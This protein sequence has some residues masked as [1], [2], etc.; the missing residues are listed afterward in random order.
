M[1]NPTKPF[2]LK[3]VVGRAT[4]SISLRAVRLSNGVLAGPKGGDSAANAPE[5]TPA[6]RTQKIYASCTEVKVLDSKV[7]ASQSIAI[8]LT[9]PK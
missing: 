3:P 1:A 8:C 9:F 2:V 7:D 6:V 5:T 4:P